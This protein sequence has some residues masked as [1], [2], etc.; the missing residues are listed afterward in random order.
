MEDTIIELQNVTKEYRE[1]KAVNKL[2]LSIKKGEIFGLL[3][4]NGA[5][6][7]TTIFM[8]LGLTEP[9]EGEVSVCGLHA[10]NQP[11]EVKKQV[12]F[13]PDTVGFYEDMTGIENLMLTGELNGLRKQ[14][15]KRRGLEL[16]QQ[17]GLGDVADKKVGKFS[18][19]MKQRLGLAD[20]LMKNPK[21]MILD[22][23]TL[24]I[25]P[26]GIKQFLTLIEELSKEK[27]I[28][29][30]LSSH[31]LHHVQRICDRVGIFVNGELMA[32]G[33]M[34]QLQR[35]LLGEETY[36]YNI[37]VPIINDRVTNVL[38]SLDDVKHVSVSDKGYFVHLDKRDEG[39]LIQHLVEREVPIL[40]FEHVSLGLDEIYDRYFREG[41][42]HD[43]A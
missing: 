4:P 41:D 29:V 14:E 13:L 39:D 10:T 40:G 34:E 9:T 38:E 27:G 8:V 24:G 33:N 11:I 2:S 17:V 23:P 5:G 12:G 16:L 20:V 15:A 36:I 7:S 1:V 26:S 30:L 37:K 43:I 31:H 18:R 35:Q 28:T 32:C 3:G 22:E 42:V 21:V 6:K 25:D 19:G